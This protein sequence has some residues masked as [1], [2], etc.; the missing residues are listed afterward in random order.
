MLF[1]GINKSI[2]QRHH[3]LWTM[4]SFFHQV[5]RANRL[6][7]PV[8]EFVRADRRIQLIA[9][10]IWTLGDVT[11]VWVL[12]LFFVVN[13]YRIYHRACSPPLFSQEYFEVNV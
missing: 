6:T 11:R 13:G 5:L 8:G 1:H 3:N 4:P 9:A 10:R 12:F 2:N 7:L